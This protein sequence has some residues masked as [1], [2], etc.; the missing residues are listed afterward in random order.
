M[1]FTVGELIKIEQPLLDGD[2]LYM[3]GRYILSVRLL[4]GDVDK[5]TLNIENDENNEKHKLLY[6][7]IGTKI[8]FHF[9]WDRKDN[10]ITEL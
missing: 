4:K 1:A 7:M 6:S 10:E 9:N 5:F 8:S 3:N 2:E